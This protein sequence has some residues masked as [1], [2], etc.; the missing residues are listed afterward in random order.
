MKKIKIGYFADG[1]W[2][3]KA[4]DKLLADETLQV[5]FEGRIVI[6]GEAEIYIPKPIRS[7]EKS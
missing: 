7:V 4:L 2:S 6:D 3:H 1:P 5:A